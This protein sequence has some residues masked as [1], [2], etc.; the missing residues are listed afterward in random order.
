MTTY[1]ALVQL[2]RLLGRTAA[3]AAIAAE[4]EPEP[5]GLTEKQRGSLAT[6]L[7]ARMEEVA[8]R[9]VD[10]AA[11]SDDVSGRAAAIAFVQDR[12]TS[13][14]DLVNPHQAE[15]LLGL[16]SEAVAGWG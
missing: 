5:A 9:L 16:A 1:P 11:A 13:F 12:I 6:L 14:G 3:L 15:R 4:V 8:T 2:V 10:E 7:D